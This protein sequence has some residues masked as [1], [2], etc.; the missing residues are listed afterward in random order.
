MQDK[1]VI[2]LTD[3]RLSLIL[4]GLKAQKVLK[5]LA[6]C[7]APSLLLTRR[8][9]ARFLLKRGTENGRD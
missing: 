3:K 6:R 9:D 2:L 1:V 8:D 4:H 7:E 5:V